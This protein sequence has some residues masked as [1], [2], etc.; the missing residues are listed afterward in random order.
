M[1][2]VT[3]SRFVTGTS[4]CLLP[5][6][7]SCFDCVFVCLFVFVFICGLVSLDSPG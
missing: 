7:T 3:W 6:M 1:I 2:V 4:Q 5:G